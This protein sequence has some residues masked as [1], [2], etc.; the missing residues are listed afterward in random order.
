MGNVDYKTLRTWS[1]LGQRGTF[2][3]SLLECAEKNDKII[4]LTAD[5]CK[6]SGMDRFA[7]AYPNR[8]VNVGIAEQNMIGIA[9]GLAKKG[10]IPFATTFANFATLRANE[11]VRHFMGYMNCNI[12]FVG[13]GAGFAMEF[14]GNTHYGLEDISVIRAF[15]NITILSPSDCL[16]VNKCVKLATDINGPVYIRLTGKMNNPIVYKEDIN[17]E[18]KSNH[19]L[20]EGE[21]VLIYAT[22]S[23]TKIALLVADKLKADGI[24]PT[25]VDAYCLKPF[26][27]NELLKQKYDL[28]VTIEE[29]SI[30]GGLGDIVLDSMN[31]NGVDKKL[32]KFGTSGKYKLPGE[33]NYM[34]D[35][36]GL[37]EDD[38]FDKI[39]KIVRKGV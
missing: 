34:L 14:F 1:M 19:I 7:K 37:N 8:C 20:L 16:A 36:Y 23:M 29:H 4:G 15:P 25:I 9:A 39:V 18:I 11:Q 31:N 28:V 17:F 26:D 22:G 12:K 6:T 35:I 10:Y 2:G 33:Y 5:L 24:G 32:L 30:T 38:I 3:V 27:D 13:F 21:E